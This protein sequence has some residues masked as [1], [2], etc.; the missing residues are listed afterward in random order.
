MLYYLRVRNVLAKCNFGVNYSSNVTVSCFDSASPTAWCE[1][2]SVANYE[3]KRV[4]RIYN[5][6]CVCVCGIHSHIMTGWKYMTTSGTCEKVSACRCTSLTFLCLFSKWERDSKKRKQNWQSKDIF[7]LNSAWC[8][9][10]NIVHFISCLPFLINVACIHSS[11]KEGVM[12][13]NKP[14][15]AQCAVS[16]RSAGAGWQMDWSSEYNW[17]AARRHQAL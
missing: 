13:W 4:R 2:Q 6:C 9:V 1:S 14:L 16:G 17:P 10:H 15:Q 8:K 12:L 5:R 3:S 11:L 7:G